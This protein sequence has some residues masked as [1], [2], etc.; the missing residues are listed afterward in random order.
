MG[1][2]MKTRCEVLGMRPL[3]ASGGNCRLG[4]FWRSCFRNLWP[5]GLGQASFASPSFVFHLLKAQLGT[6]VK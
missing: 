4:R 2:Y 6:H 1:I 3:W 5:G